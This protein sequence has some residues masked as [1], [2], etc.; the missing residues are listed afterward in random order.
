MRDIKP[1]ISVISLKINGL[2][3]P[4]KRIRLSDWFKNNSFYDPNRRQ[5]LNIRIYQKKADV[6]ILPV[7]VIKIKKKQNRINKVHENGHEFFL[8]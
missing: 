2:N 8:H 5:N 7:G 4:S 6:A 3:T 1:N